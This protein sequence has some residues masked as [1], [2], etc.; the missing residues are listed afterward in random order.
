MQNKELIL[1]RIAQE[2]LNNILKYANASRIF[3]NLIYETHQIKFSIEDNGNGFNKSEVEKKQ[4]GKIHTGLNN[5]RNRAKTLNGE[6]IINSSPGNGTCI[7]II[8][9][10]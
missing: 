9:P 10:Y 7:C 2:A 8:A 5:I 1:Y 6:C 4:T 3:I